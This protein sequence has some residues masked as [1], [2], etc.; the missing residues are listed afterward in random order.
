MLPSSPPLL[1]TKLQFCSRYI[2]IVAPTPPRG[3]A[4]RECTIAH[5]YV[6]APHLMIVA[7]SVTDLT[8]PHT[9][10]RALAYTQGLSAQGTW[11][12]ACCQQV[13]S[14]TALRLH[15][16]KSTPRRELLPAPG[17]RIVRLTVHSDPREHWR[18]ARGIL[19]PRDAHRRSLGWRSMDCSVLLLRRVRSEADADAQSVHHVA[20]D[21]G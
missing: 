13:S 18:G 9:G 2:C 17:R 19:T 15:V 21:R 1:P 12:Q 11:A 16:A 4:R 8:A 3:H 5:S 20:Y 14:P 6:S 7:S 10:H